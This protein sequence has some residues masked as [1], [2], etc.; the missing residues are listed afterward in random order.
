MLGYCTS[1][2]LA[3]AYN[4]IPVDENLNDNDG[5]EVAMS[6]HAFLVSNMIMIYEESMTHMSP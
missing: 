5:D 1:E 4:T 3:D 6:L 2:Q